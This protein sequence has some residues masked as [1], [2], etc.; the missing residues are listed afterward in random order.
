MSWLHHLLFGEDAKPA[1]SA[2][3]AERALSGQELM[4]VNSIFEATEEL[5]PTAQSLESAATRGVAFAC[6]REVA[7][8]VQKAELRATG[9][10]RVLLQSP[11]DHDT[12]GDLLEKMVFE[13]MATGTAYVLKDDV[14]LPSELRV[15]QTSKVV[16]RPGAFDTIRHLSYHD[17]NVSISDLDPELCVIWRAPYGRSP[18]ASAW[19]SVLVD[20]ARQVYERKALERLPYMIGVAE[21][22]SETT[23]EQREELRVAIAKVLGTTIVLP[24]GAKLQMPSMRDM[25]HL[26]GL[27]SQVESRISA[28]L[29]VPAIVVGLQA[30]L[31]RSTY[32]NYAEARH[33]FREETIRPL[34]ES[35]SDTMS[36]GLGGEVTF[37]LNTRAEAAE[38]AT[39]ETEGD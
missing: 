17:R 6:I 38:D 5:R 7:Q 34:L 30:G 8:A 27:A 4:D 11:N 12:L 10:V 9:R 24:Q 3:E 35:L 26:P 23:K 25:L 15:L 22:D 21:T 20:E 18:L 31:E 28:A 13:Y 37:E 16:R 32:A 19:N 33:S 39:P 14:M 2:P 29:N 1:P 36:R